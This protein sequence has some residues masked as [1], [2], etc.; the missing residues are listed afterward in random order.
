MTRFS[1]VRAGRVDVEGNE[2]LF[3]P[4]FGEVPASIEYRRDV[5]V[6][7]YGKRIAYHGT[8]EALIDLGVNPKR[9]KVSKTTPFRQGQCIESFGPPIHLSAAATHCVSGDGPEVTLLTPRRCYWDARLQPDGTILYRDDTELAECERR[10]LEEIRRYSEQDR[11]ERDRPTRLSFC[12]SMLDALVGSADGRHPY[13]PDAL[14]TESLAR[15]RDHAA[16]ILREV[17]HAARLC[18][19]AP[20][21]KAARPS[22]L[23]LV[24]DNEVHT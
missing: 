11:S 20:S 7:H 17:R 15:V 8:R 24:V 19:D 2:V 14:P 22:H 13:Y 23:R 3:T 6:V 9:L 10:E 4:D 12:D 1:P 21:S 16:A 18:T 5:E